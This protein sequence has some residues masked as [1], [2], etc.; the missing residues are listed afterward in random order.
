MSKGKGRTVSLKKK[1]DGKMWDIFLPILLVIVVVPLVVRLAVYDC[2]YGEY[3]WYS[4]NGLL[5]DFFSY[6]K[7]NLISL[8]GV[9]SLII[10]VFFIVL[11]KERIKPLWAFLPLGGYLIFVLLSSVF[12]VN[13]EAAWKGNIGSFEGAIVLCSYGVFAL[14]TYLF[15]EEERD[16]KILLYGIYLITGVF[17]VIGFL[18]V[19]G[20]DPFDFE[21]VQRSMMTNEQYMEYRNQI[22]DTFSG[23]RVYLTLYNPN[24]AGVV[25]SMLF[26]FFFQLLLSEEKKNMR[27]VYT[28][29]IIALLILIW[30]TYSRASLI[31][32]GI[33]ALYLLFRN[34]KS[35]HSGRKRALGVGMILLFAGIIMGLFLFDL[36][37]GKTYS[38][39]MIDEKREP[40]E[41]MTI[42]SSGVS[43]RYDGRDYEVT[44]GDALVVSDGKEL[45]TA[46]EGERI[47]LPF[48]E[49]AEVFFSDDSLY[50]YLADNIITFTRKDGVW[51]YQTVDQKLTGLPEIAHAD[52]FGLEY[53]FSARGYIWS[54][55]IPLLLHHMILGS[56]PDTYAESFPQEDYIGKIVYSDRPD[57]IIEKAHND[58]LTKWVQ[59]GFFSLL[60]LLIFY[61]FVMKSGGKLFRSVEEKKAGNQRMHIR[62]ALGSY[63]ACLSYMISSLVNDSTVQTA[64]LFFVC[65]GIVLAFRY[66]KDYNNFGS[67]DGAN[68]RRMEREL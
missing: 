34:R 17:C 36:G 48:D 18:Q 60:C 1:N 23:N 21:W 10:L 4:D 31:T 35:K 29:T 52:L 14:Y 16:Y 5:S 27:L 42:T 20:C 43:L 62:I 53:L 63:A 38:S 44:V 15:L 68:K 50:F 61:G 66:G 26:C 13:R 39:R 57:R 24:Y 33:V 47:R 6:Y 28:G 25:L 64:P 49:E 37:T 54:R 9:I 19:A 46:K 32:A 30:F 51:F 56:G 3:I 11:Y 59:T 7:S 40:L 22:T 58:Y 67:T 41:Q 65:C 55:T 45:L 2:G 8:L 12:S